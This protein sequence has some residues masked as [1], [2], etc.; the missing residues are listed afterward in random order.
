MDF[1]N[2]NGSWLPWYVRFAES[3]SGS[4]LSFHILLL[5]C[6]FSH[7]HFRTSS[8]FQKKYSCELLSILILDIW[9]MQTYHLLYH[10]VLFS[11]R[12]FSHDIR[13][14]NCLSG[15]GENAIYCIDLSVICCN[16][17]IMYMRI[18]HFQISN[19]KCN[20]RTSSRLTSCLL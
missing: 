12:R 3:V 11:I 15:F 6:Y 4:Q 1:C 13:Q 19:V 9:L 17:P 14:C 10:K 5:S 7:H 20:Q 8:N 16:Q 2:P 18:C